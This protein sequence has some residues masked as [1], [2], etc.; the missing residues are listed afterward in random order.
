[1]CAKIQTKAQ[2]ISEQNSVNLNIPHFFWHLE[3]FNLNLEG[4]VSKKSAGKF[5]L[6]EFCSGYHYFLYF[7]ALGHQNN[8]NFGAKIEKLTFL[9]N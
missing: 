5:K 2:R 3:V 6:S 4:G 8:W 7:C 9:Q 1:M